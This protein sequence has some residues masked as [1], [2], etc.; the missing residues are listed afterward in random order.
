MP[1]KQPL[2]RRPGGRAIRLRRIGLAAAVAAL[3]ALAAGRY[4]LLYRDL[5]DGEDHLLA[6]AEL[7]EARGLDIERN[8]LDSAEA[9]FQRAQDKL[10]SASHALNSDPLLFVAA[11]LPRAGSQVEAARNLA[12][13]GADGSDIGLEAV[14]AMRS[15]Q[16]VRDTQGGALSERV[17]L[18]LDA[19]EPNVAVIEDELA[20]VDR[21]RQ[22]IADDGLLAPLDSALT[23]LDNHIREL[24]A[25]LA[26][27]RRGAR[28]A[29][30]LLGYDGPRTYLV[31]AHDNTE[32]LGS[33]GFILV[34][35]LLT[36]DQG[37]LTQLFFDDIGSIYFDW[38]ARTGEYIEPPRPLKNYLL[39]DWPMGLGEASW[40]P[41]FPTAA[42]AAIELY[43]RESGSDEPIDGVI[44]INFLTLEKL[45]AVIGPIT[46]DEYGVTVNDQNVTEQT[47][48]VTHPETSRPWETDRYDFVGYLAED[49]IEKTMGSDA[50][51]WAPMLGAVHT[52]G[53]EKNLL[54][55]STDQETQKVIAELA[56]DGSVRP[57]DG[58]YLMVVD[59]S[60]N[61]TK[62]NLVV[63][64]SIE[65][66]ISIDDLGN[67]RNTVTITYASDYQAWARDQDP[68]LASLVV[69]AG[70]L[71]VYGDYLRLLV[72]S[73]SSVQDV[74]EEGTQAGIEAIWQEHG[75]TVLGR[76][77][78]LPLDTAKTL[79]FTYLVPSALDTSQ[80]PF[81]YRLLIQK[82][83]GTAA[84]PLKI[85][86][87]PPHWAKDTLLELDGRP[88][89]PGSLAVDTDLRVDRSLVVTIVPQRSER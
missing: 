73:G 28:L 45:L 56:W 46:V 21:R 30:Q 68:H 11:H 53:E 34:Y 10:T 84:I 27:Y 63:E 31:L 52:L 23:K 86:V 69:G 7:M 26:D 82:Q 71:T 38:R 8:E 50:P 81:T 79:A 70:T 4:A 61:S 16:T 42:Q 9:S 18:V 19:V 13:S 29:P 58:D 54:L 14:R 87:E 36:F 12:E 1:R 2:L 55:Y 60:L 33:G 22:S 59:S 77:F 24:R 40:W 75:K 15:F 44:G 47:L 39:R 35:G 5:A 57:T 66:D 32:I 72:P 25:R 48:I 20:S 76:Y 37:R 43:R 89:E 41:D 6:A 62:L 74:L 88:V 85:R 64:P 80:A 83:P 51:K 17:T 78:A 67:A 65:A 3:I 49:V